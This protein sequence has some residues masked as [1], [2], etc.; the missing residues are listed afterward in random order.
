MDHV[1][2]MKPSWKLLRK[3][4]NGEKKIESR[5]YKTR[6][7]AWG[8]VKTGDI[9]WFK[10]SGQPVTVR[11]KA[12]RVL[13]FSDLTP[14]KVRRIIYQ[15]GGKDGIALS[16]LEYFFQWAKNKK[17]CVLVFLETPQPVARPFKINKRG[18]GMSRA[19]LTI[20]DIATIKK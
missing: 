20:K 1:A 12:G 13:E 4:V 18:F 7:E 11:A 17:Y 15:Y 9:I 6:R 2:I 5:W 14:E 3:I 16:R 8:K 19:W 10:D